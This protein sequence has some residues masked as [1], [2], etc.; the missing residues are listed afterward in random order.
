MKNSCGFR[1]P[2]VCTKTSGAQV[3]AHLP[4]LSQL[5]RYSYNITINILLSP[6]SSLL[7]SP[8]RLPAIFSHNQQVSFGLSVSSELP[9]NAV[10]HKCE[11]C[12]AGVPMLLSPDLL[13]P[14]VTHLCLHARFN[15][16]LSPLPNSLTHLSFGTDFNQPV[17]NLPPNLKHLE[18]SNFFDHPVDHLPHGLT[19]L[20]FRLQF[21]H[22]VDQLP[23]SLL[24][25]QFEN[26]FIHP[27]D[28]FPSFT[29]EASVM[30]HQQQIQP[31][32]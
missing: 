4:F 3:H 10:L 21:N 24:Q 28:W 9:I 17:D 11:Q 6:L 13:S 30:E 23:F 32:P 8:A 14:Q 26:H 20:T 15:S 19:H 16:P 7:A 22:S 5:Y 12:D 2:L 25:L 31:L 18:L 1:G 29:R 27:L